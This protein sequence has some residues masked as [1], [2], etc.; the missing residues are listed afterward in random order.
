ME[1]LIKAL[2]KWYNLL[3][4]IAKIQA[5][6]NKEEAL[7]AKIQSELNR[8]GT[9]YYKSQK[10]SIAELEKE[11]KTQQ[12]LVDAQKKEREKRVSEL[13]KGKAPFSKMYEVDEDG[14]VKMKSK[15]KKEYDKYFDDTDTGKPKKSIKE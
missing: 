7:R 2:D 11:I 5:K 15:F 6:L 12:E 10:R 8:S 3:Q 4:E 14:Q 1:G 13:K 9:D